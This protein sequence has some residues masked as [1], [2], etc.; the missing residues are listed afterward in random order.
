MGEFAFLGCGSRQYCPWPEAGWVWLGPPCRELLPI[1][2]PCL[3][4]TGQSWARVMKRNRT[5]SASRR[6]CCAVN[7]NA[8]GWEIKKKKKNYCIAMELFSTKLINGI[9]ANG[10][11][12]P[13]REVNSWNKAVLRRSKWGLMGSANLWDA[14]EDPMCLHRE[15]VGWSRWRSGQDACRPASPCLASVE[16]VDFTKPQNN[17]AFEGM[18]GQPNR[19]FSSS[20][21]Y[22]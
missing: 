14:R 10:S 11:E 1:R 20:C 5:R 7:G 9:L 22:C 4:L 8:E 3:S 17:Q 21:S 16:Y 13:Q 2:L 18:M 19:S 15:G 6:I 12:T